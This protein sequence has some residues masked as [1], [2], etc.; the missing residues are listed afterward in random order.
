MV[1]CTPDNFKIALS[2]DRKRGRRTT[3][4][5]LVENT[6]LFQAGDPRYQF[7]SLRLERVHVPLIRLSLNYSNTRFSSQ[8]LPPFRPNR[9]SCLSFPLISL[10]FYIFLTSNLSSCVV[11]L[12][13][14]FEIIPISFLS[15]Y[16]H[17]IDQSINHSIPRFEKRK[18]N[19]YVPCSQLMKKRS[20][21]SLISSFNPLQLHTIR[22]RAFGGISYR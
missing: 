14:I 6:S 1:V 10:S 5:G 4:Q 11:S 7:P 17:S 20:P 9:N 8:L 18:T 16:D 15:L 22:T 3:T 12:R 21:S 13:A 2:K 19:E